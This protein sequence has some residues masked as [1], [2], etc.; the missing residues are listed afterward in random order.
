MKDLYFVIGF[1]LVVFLIYRSVEVEGNID[2]LKGVEIPRDVLESYLGK[3]YQVLVNKSTEIRQTKQVNNDAINKTKDLISD[4]QS[5]FF[6]LKPLIPNG[7]IDRKN[8]PPAA[9]FYAAIKFVDGPNVSRHLMNL[10][11][12]KCK[13]IY[14]RSGHTENTS[15][16]KRKASFKL[17]PDKFTDPDLKR[18]ATDVFQ[19]FENCPLNIKYEGRRAGWELPKEEV[20]VVPDGICD[21]TNMEFDDVDKL[22]DNR[23][24]GASSPVEFDYI[25]YSW[26]W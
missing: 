19:Y 6:E 5:F 25:D 1:A 17:H 13:Y 15:K 16:S 4:L 3:K 7:P 24:H 8:I 9:Y 11:V 22:F 18:I 14:C 12:S 2:F 10:H 26:G 20:S 21:I 23:R